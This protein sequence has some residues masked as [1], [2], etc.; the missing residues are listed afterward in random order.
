MERVTKI[1]GYLLVEVPFN[2]PYHSP[3]YDFFRFTYTGLRSLFAKC[4]LYSYEA[5]EGNAS[6]VAVFNAQFLVDLFSN[7]YLRI[8][9]L[10][11]SRFLFGWIKYI[12]LLRKN[13][14]YK[15]TFSPM[16][17]SMIF[18]KDNKQRS[19]IELLDE[20]YKLKTYS[21]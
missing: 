8:G 17:I 21:K 9:M 12:D 5:S 13:S 7:R 6:T 10:F 15:S 18:K 16:G 20:F 19:N 1:G 4:S 2:F 11:L 3:P 14:T